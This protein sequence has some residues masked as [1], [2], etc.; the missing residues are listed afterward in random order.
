MR[1]QATGMFAGYQL[2]TVLSQSSTSTVFFAR[3]PLAPNGVAIKVVSPEVTAALGLRDRLGIE[4]ERIARLSH[5]NIVEIYEQGVTDDSFWQAIRYVHG[6]DASRLDPRTVTTAR[7][8]R[9]VSEA[10]AALDYAHSQGVLHREVK[11]ANIML[12]STEPG[13]NDRALVAGF[14]SAE[15]A[16]TDIRPVLDSVAP[17]TISHASPELLSGKLVDHRSDQYSLACTLFTI[18]AGSS[19]FAAPSAEQV[20]A[21][22]LNS[23]VPSLAVLRSD[24]PPQLDEVIARAMAKNPNQ[25]FANCTEFASAVETVLTSQS[26]TPTPNTHVPKAAR[27]STRTTSFLVLLSTVSLVATV[28]QLSYWYLK[29]HRF[30]REHNEYNLEPQRLFYSTTAG[31]FVV[32]TVAYAATVL[33]L[34]FNR[35]IGRHTLIGS[36]AALLG[37]AVG[38][39][40]WRS[41]AHFEGVICDPSVERVLVSAAILL[42][43][44]A[45]A[46][47]WFSN[48]EVR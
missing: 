48:R 37:T 28:G 23:P 3:H 47:P 4:T 29:V 31:A 45:V 26:S 39:E 15:L 35:R 7:A 12:C 6:T 22:H 43:S 42:S 17:S 10:A 27:E 1:P 25:R 32:L 8:L 16:N 2:D 38:V 24:V 5:P 11:P 14:G 30:G 13:I 19:P 46:L 36:V 44:V 18:L 21:G 20:V 9:I 33:L 41:T 40:Y 34:L